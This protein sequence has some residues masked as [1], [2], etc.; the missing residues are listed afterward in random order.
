MFPIY[1][2]QRFSHVLEGLVPAD[3]LPFISTAQLALRIFEFPVLAFHRILQTISCETL[4]A[5]RMAANATALLRICGAV[6]VGIVCLL[7]HYDSIPHERFVHATPAAIVPACSAYPHALGRPAVFRAFNCGHP[8][9]ATDEAS[10]RKSGS[11]GNAR[12]DKASTAHLR[13]GSPIV[14]ATRHSPSPLS[15]PPRSSFFESATRVKIPNVNCHVPKIETF[16]LESFQI[17]NEQENLK[18][19]PFKPSV[20]HLTFFAPDVSLRRE[21]P[22]FARGSLAHRTPLLRAITRLSA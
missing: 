7:P 11:R 20:K 10:R 21:P 19:P 15:Y 8:V 22:A 17:L 6:F 3:T 2:P 14:H 12:L 13:H 5:L 18:A 4:F 1:L 9:F 16:L